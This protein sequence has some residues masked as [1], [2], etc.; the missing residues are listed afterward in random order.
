MVNRYNIEIDESASVYSTAGEFS[1]PILGNILG[2]LLLLYL[3]NFYESQEL[4]ALA[5]TIGH[6]YA[7]IRDYSKLPQTAGTVYKH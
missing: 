3:K 7:G 6:T 4:I 5:E 2:A 1:G